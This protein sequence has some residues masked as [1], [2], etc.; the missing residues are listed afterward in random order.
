MED[1]TP[2]QIESKI[3]E[4]VTRIARGINHCNGTYQ[5]KLRASAVYDRAFAAAYMAHEG[6][7]HER[8]YAAELATQVERQD[9]DVADAAHR[10]AESLARGLRDEL[11]ALRSLGA[12]VREAYRMAGS[13][14]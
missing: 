9:R 8:K 6:P 5:A 11:D 4:C 1:L 7:A 10:Y 2:V 12:S 13:A 14:S 3:R